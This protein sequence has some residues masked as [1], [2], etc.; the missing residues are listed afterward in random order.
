M[1]IT[2]DLSQAVGSVPAGIYVT[3]VQEV[4]QRNSKAGNPYL[5]W[6]L[7]VVE[8]AED[9]FNGSII[10]HS[11]PYTGKGAG[12]FENFWKAC[13]GEALPAGEAIDPE[14][15]LGRN[16]KTTVVEGVDQ[17]GN[18]TGFPKVK[19]VAAA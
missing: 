17:Q 16:I 3:L 6:K 1:N 11:T 2:P 4:E 13:T 7:Q 15:M 8:N 12:I 19:S 14:V 9:K 5:N 18:P 10:Y